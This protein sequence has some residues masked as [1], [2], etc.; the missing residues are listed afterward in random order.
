[1]KSVQ[2]RRRRYA[3]ALGVIFSAIFVGLALR[4]IDVGALGHALMAS[5]WWP[6]YAIAPVLYMTGHFVRGQR[7]RTIL[8]PHCDLDEW[9]ATNCTI[10]GYAANNLLPARMGELVRAY[11]LGRR[12]NVSVSLALAI[13]LLERLL[14]GLVITGVLLVAGLFAPLPSWGRHLLWLAAAIFVS[15]SIAV[16]LTAIARPFV[17][18]VTERVAAFLPRRMGERIS[19]MLDRA[20]GATDCLRDAT[21]MAK[22]ITLSVAVW[23]VEG[24][25]FLVILPAFSLPMKPLWAGMALSIT[26]LGVLVPS[27]PG[28]IGPFHYFCMLALRIFGVPRETALGYAIMAHLL[29]YVPVTLWGVLAL[30]A[31]GVDLSS[32][33]RSA[34]ELNEETVAEV[35]A[36]GR[37]AVG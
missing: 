8:R 36:D 26:N 35:V 2:Q 10:I 11:V 4:Q 20:F 12:A 13:T 34:R 3:V 27:S 24:S 17:L 28:Y 25:M 5:H 32:A 9:T 30:A 16:V 31:Y 22:I 29:Y 6:W 14:D 21:L 18:A 15:A 23:L 37:K 33:A 7:C 19:P 1:L